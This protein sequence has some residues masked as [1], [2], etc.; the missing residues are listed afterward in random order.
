MSEPQSVLG[1]GKIIGKW[2]LCKE[3]GRGGQ[4]TVWAVRENVK[5]KHRPPYAMKVCTDGSAVGR[6]RFETEVTILRSLQAD[7]SRCA[8]CPTVLDSCDMNW[9]EG[10]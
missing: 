3:L 8:G 4:G 6:R 9:E 10:G 2:E 5:V 7:G 1:I